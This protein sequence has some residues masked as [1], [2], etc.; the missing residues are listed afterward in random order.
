L[1]GADFGRL[2]M[3]LLLLALLDLAAAEVGFLL[4]DALAR[5]RRGR[6]GRRP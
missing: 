1:L 2:G 5:P 6:P 4:I 3:P